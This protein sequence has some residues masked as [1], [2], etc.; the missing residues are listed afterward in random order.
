MMKQLVIVLSFCTFAY[1]F[2]LPRDLTLKDP[3]PDPDQTEAH[4]KGPLKEV[5]AAMNILIRKFLINKFQ[6]PKPKL[7]FGVFTQEAWFKTWI[8]LIL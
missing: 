6:Q 7:D 8:T 2:L 1:G 5:Q 4:G 3:Q